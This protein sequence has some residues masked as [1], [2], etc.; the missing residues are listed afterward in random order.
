MRLF[1]L[2]YFPIL[3]EAIFRCFRSNLTISL[4]PRRAHL[5]GRQSPTRAY[6]MQRAYFLRSTFNSSLVNNSYSLAHRTVDNLVP[7]GFNNGHSVLGGCCAMHTKWER[8]QTPLDHFYSK[9]TDLDVSITEIPGTRPGKSLG[10]AR[11]RPPTTGTACR[12][13]P[14]CC[15]RH[16]GDSQLSTRLG[17]ILP[18]STLC[19]ERRLRIDGDIEPWSVGGEEYG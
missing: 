2:S 4:P 11:L 16:H 6:N 10:L 8:R 14:Q 9:R 5:S 12:A 18:P 3:I 1:P 7:T 15:F 19:G 13:R 17:L